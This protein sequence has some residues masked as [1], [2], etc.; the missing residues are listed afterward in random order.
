MLRLDN[1]LETDVSRLENGGGRLRLKNNI[2]SLRLD[3]GMDEKLNCGRLRLN[4]G[5]RRSVHS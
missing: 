4:N 5:A 1:R 2:E 3:Y